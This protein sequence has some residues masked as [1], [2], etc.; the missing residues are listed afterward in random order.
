MGKY[1][2]QLEDVTVVFG[3]MIVTE[4]KEKPLYWYNYEV[5]TQGFYPRAII[6][7]I[8]ITMQ[9][10]YKFYISNQFGIGAHK[11]LNGG[12]PSYAHFSLEGEFKPS[13]RKRLLKLD[14]EAYYKRNVERE[15]WQKEYYP[16]EYKQVK[17]LEETLK[18]FRSKG[19]FKVNNN[20]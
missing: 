7:A 10:G 19:M 14:E 11:L 17:A 8:E 18:N 1:Q 13:R 5:H 6:P 4:N 12:R 3:D 16:E 2:W 20:T 9:D 15:A